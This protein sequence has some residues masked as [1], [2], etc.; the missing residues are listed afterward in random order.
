[1]SDRPAANI[2]LEIAAK[3]AK[4]APGIRLA[5]DITEAIAASRST[6][7]ARVAELEAEAEGWKKAFAAQSRKLQHVLPVA[8]VK[9]A[10]AELTWTK[11]GRA[12]LAGH[13]PAEGEAK[14]PVAWTALLEDAGYRI[15]GPDEVDAETVERCAKCG[16]AWDNPSVLLL[17]AGEMTAQE[18]RTAR[19]VS[20]GIAAAIRAMVKP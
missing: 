3:H 14:G 17:A 13:A 8:G 7:A 19:A 5:R 1:M 12:A 2:A 16:D 11:A 15:V 20:R 10:L 18:L 9:E 6:D 4:G